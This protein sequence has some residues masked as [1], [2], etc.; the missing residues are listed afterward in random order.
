MENIEIDLNAAKNGKLD[1][2]FLRSFGYQIE[3]ILKQMFGLHGG[4]ARITGTQD[5]LQSFG[6]TLSG[7]KQYM[8]AYNKHGLGNE[9]TFQSKWQLDSAVRNFENETGLKWPL[10]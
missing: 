7:E 2:S 10:K 1:E 8:E 6:R 5:Q 9:A 4:D 3:Y